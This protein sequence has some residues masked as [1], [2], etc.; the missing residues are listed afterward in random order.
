M[1]ISRKGALKLIIV[2][3][4]VAAALLIYTKTVDLHQ[5]TTDKTP[6]SSEVLSQ[7]YKSDDFG[8]SIRLSESWKDYLV[9]VSDLKFTDENNQVIA[10]HVY[11]FSFMLPTTFKPWLDSGS[12]RG[13]AFSIS[14]FPKR[15]L[16]KLKVECAKPDVYWYTCAPLNTPL[17]ENNKYVFTYLRTDKIT[18]YPEDFVGTVFE[19]AD[20]AKATFKTFDTNVTDVSGSITQGKVIKEWELVE[21][22]AQDTC[23]HPTF[24]G[25][26]IVYGWY[27]YADDYVEKAWQFHVSDQDLYNLPV[28]QLF[29]GT[30]SLLF[31]YYKTHPLFRLYKNYVTHT[32]SNNPVNISAALEAKLKNASAQKPYPIR[33]T[34]FSQYCE[35]SGV[36]V[37]KE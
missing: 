19:Q 29:N 7:E 14:A 30:E 3:V 6:N 25:E 27:E 24:K 4:T 21:G 31:S 37:V 18:D 8:F 10:E 22:E 1:N 35:G 15:D 12:T 26:A 36:I 34:Q 23:T 9:N 16:S 11:H 5:E 2:L 32:E 33:V 28:N 20:L 13:E 17:A